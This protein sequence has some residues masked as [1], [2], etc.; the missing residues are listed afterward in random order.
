MQEKPPGFDQ[1]VVAAAVALNFVA[2]QGAEDQEVGHDHEL[3]LGEGCVL[4]YQAAYHV[5][6][7]LKINKHKVLGVFLFT[8]GGNL[9]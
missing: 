9:N 3:G 1:G 4:P 7:Y 6:G 5:V 8:K 2:H